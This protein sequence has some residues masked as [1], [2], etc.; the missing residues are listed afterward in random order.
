MM[1]TDDTLA[2]LPPLAEAVTVSG[3]QITITP[4]KVGELPAFIRAVK[5]FA[6]GIGSNPDWL[7]LISDHGEAVIDAL[8]IASRQPREWV[9]SLDLDDA[10]RLA[11]VIFEA[12]ADFFIRRLVPEAT[13]IGAS[14]SRLMDGRTPSKG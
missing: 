2:G 14:I 12:N 8:A 7:A 10:M 6:A 9:A 4:I 3:A 13:R 11:D 5:P 1:A